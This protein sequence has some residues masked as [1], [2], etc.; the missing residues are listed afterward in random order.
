M[1]P[2]RREDR[3][4]RH[5][6]VQDL[7]QGVAGAPALAESSLRLAET[8][9]REAC[10]LA[11]EALRAPGLGESDRAAALHA[12]ARGCLQLGELTAARRAVAAAKDLALRRADLDELAELQAISAVLWFHAELPER[13]LEEFAEA[14]AAGDSRPP[15]QSTAYLL[16]QKALLCFRLGR[17]EEGFSDSERALQMLSALG[18]PE[19]SE[20]REA[21]VRSNRGLARLYLGSYEEA[22]ADLESALRLHRTA[23]ADVLEAQ[24]LHN[25]GCVAARLGEVPMGLKRFE[26]A[27][28]AYSRLGLPTHQLVAD[29]AGLLLA[30]RLIPEARQALA[31]ASDELERAGLGADAAEARLMLAE[32]CLADHDHPAALES[33]KSAARSFG[34]QNRHDWQVLAE[35]VEARVHRAELVLAG[36]DQVEVFSSAQRSAECLEKAGWHLEA[37]AARVCGA[38]AALSMGRKDLVASLFHPPSDRSADPGE[39]RLSPATESVLVLHAKALGQLASNR[40]EEALS[41]LRLC[42][43]EAAKRAGDLR[44]ETG[45]AGHGAALADVTRTALQA[46]AAAGSPA[47]LLEWSELCRMTAPSTAARRHFSAEELLAA[48]CGRVLVEIVAVGTQLLAVVGRSGSLHLLEL[49]PAGVLESHAAG[50]SFALRQL[51]VTHPARG[52]RRSAPTPSRM[53]MA[54]LALRSARALDQ[55]LLGPAAPHLEGGEEIVLVPSGAL[56]EL[57]VGALPSLE[58]RAVTVVPTASGF[59]AASP[60][61]PRLDRARRPAR[62]LLVAGPGVRGA[63][64]EL[65]GLEALYRDDEVTVLAGEQ[66][67]RTAVLD[68]FSSNDVA[69]LAL[70]GQFRADNPLMSS[71]ELFDGPLTVHE[72]RA[73]RQLPGCVILSACDAGRVAVHP[74]EELTGPVPALIAGPD[75]RPTSV[76]AA[77]APLIDESMPSLSLLLHEAIAS[78]MEP[79]QALVSARARTGSL[80]GI[81]P[82]ELARG[83]SVSAS[84]LSLA[85]MVTYGR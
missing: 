2:R 11:R 19:G 20:T 4:R 17:Y 10:R 26:E 58:R 69:H 28:A 45:R 34:R 44:E 47:E 70:H 3:G 38:Q 55:L 15:S 23:G 62:I 57:A 9:P 51:A 75:G 53:A 22:L 14:I 60:V 32:A 79:S 46:A 6:L 21:K 16:G 72:I 81:S 33:A 85:C 39:A 54:E 71:L 68:C 27:L 52:R 73:A 7:N 48:L 13:A 35:E 31:Q 80:S 65:A 42:V 74:G 1:P 41:T 5:E 77:V 83:D 8:D 12:L 84:V 43:T 30:A 36:A 25:L 67:T 29:R 56:H 78:G 63:S 37:L 18:S 66:A 49:G 40:R 82:T 64:A 61:G 50:L 59:C 24:V 76:V